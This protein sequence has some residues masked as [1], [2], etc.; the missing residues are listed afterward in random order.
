MLE[1]VATIRPRAID[2]NHPFLRECLSYKS[3]RPRE[4][5]VNRMGAST[6]YAYALRPTPYDVSHHLRKVLRQESLVS[7]VVKCPIARNLKHAL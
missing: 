3:T 4:L 6:P 1:P 5:K 2:F 7:T